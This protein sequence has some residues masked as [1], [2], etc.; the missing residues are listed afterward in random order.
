MHKILCVATM[1]EAL[2]CINIHSTILATQKRCLSKDKME[3]NWSGLITDLAPQKK[4]SPE[5][6]VEPRH[7]HTLD[8]NQLHGIPFGTVDRYPLPHHGLTWKCVGS[9][10]FP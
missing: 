5:G 9:G 7:A 8:D 10:C 3:A 1:T 2:A 6:D 4:L